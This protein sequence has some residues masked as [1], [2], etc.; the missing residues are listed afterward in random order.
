MPTV[1]RGR[2]KKVWAFCELE[3]AGRS[4]SA[5]NCETSTSKFAIRS[6]K[7]SGPMLL[8]TISKHT[9]SPTNREQYAVHSTQCT[10]DST[11]HTIYNTQYRVNNTRFT[12][13]SMQY[14]VHNAQYTRRMIRFTIYNSQN[15]S[16]LVS[17][18]NLR[19]VLHHLSSLTRWNG[20]R[21]QVW[22]GSDRKPKLQ[23]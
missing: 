18:A 10:I 20:S 15:A 3:D 7:T 22:P 9:P 17:G 14:T 19:C 1:C 16:A 8:A 2:V 21:G 12:M 13:H 4:T 23:L 6:A 11:L 5:G